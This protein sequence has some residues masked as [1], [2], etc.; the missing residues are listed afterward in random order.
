MILYINIYININVHI[1]AVNDDVIN[2]LFFFDKILIFL[3]KKDIIAA[4]EVKKY[5]KVFSGCP[6]G[7]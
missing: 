7:G 3:K 4:G 5:G 1:K 6:A 2:S